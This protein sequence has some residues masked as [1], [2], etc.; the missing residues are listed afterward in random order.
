MPLQSRTPTDLQ[1]NVQFCL[2]YFEKLKDSQRLAGVLRVNRTTIGHWKRYENVPRTKNLDDL[3]K[4]C[5]FSAAQFQLPHAQFVVF[6]HTLEATKNIFT[7]FYAI[8]R[9][10]ILAATENFRHDWAR[11]FDA[12]RGTYLMFCRALSDPELGA[13]SLL[14]IKDLTEDGIAFDLFNR[15]TRQPDKPTYRYEGL[16][17]PIAENLMFYAEHESMREPFAMITSA[18]QVPESSMLGGFFIAVA[19]HGQTRFPNGNRVA[20]RFRD[21]AIVDLE[22][23]ESSLGLKRFSEFPEGVRHLL[24]RIG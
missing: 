19:V 11:C 20:L 8:Q 2:S 22:K 23:I 6:A 3:A 14:R 16:V 18:A 13:T 15:D 5:G 24:G 9:K 4:I 17:F 10:I 21:R 7:D 1:R 12:H